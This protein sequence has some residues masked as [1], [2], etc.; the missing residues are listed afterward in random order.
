ML[1]TFLSFNV[2]KR[3]SKSL[4]SLPDSIGKVFEPDSRFCVML[5]MPLNYLNPLL[6]VYHP[7]NP[8]PSKVAILRTRTPA[9]E[10][11]TLPLEGPRILRAVQSFS[12]FSQHVFVVSLG[13]TCSKPEHYAIIN[14]I[15]WNSY[16]PCMVYLHVPYK[17]IIGQHIF[18]LWQK[19]LYI[20]GKM[21]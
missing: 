16:D 19:K 10:V 13:G 8:D 20:L 14:N 9:I 21:L 7:K 11:Q 15:S 4:C 5:L 6:K 17:S 1:S 2:F 3:L 12:P 18:I